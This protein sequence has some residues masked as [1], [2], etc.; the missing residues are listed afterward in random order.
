MQD[1]NGTRTIHVGVIDAFTDWELAYA[2]A[3]LSNPLWQKRPGTLVVKTV[4]VSLATV[5][6]LGS[7]TV[8]PDMAAA[9]LRPQNSAMLILPGSSSFGSGAGEAFV[10]KAKEFLA[11]GVSVAAI[12]GATFA[13]ARGGVLDERRHTSNAPEYLAK[14]GYR[15]AAYYEN[16]GAVTDGNLITASGINPVDFARQIFEKLD[17]HVPKVIEALTAL[18]KTGDPRY[19]YDAMTA[20]GPHT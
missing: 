15:G 11:A 18:H 13:L 19:F 12:C 5:R 20:A 16:A 17:S 1:S 6:S 3:Y 8:Q 9:D 2:M 14:T 4:G 10:A 7:L